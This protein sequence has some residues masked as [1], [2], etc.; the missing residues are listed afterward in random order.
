MTLSTREP[1]AIRAAVVAAVNA[2]FKVF[3]IAGIIAIGPE[4]E[5]AVITAVDLVATAVLVVWTRGK[6]TPVAAPLLPDDGVPFSI[7]DG[8]GRYRAEE[9]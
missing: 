6:V 9:V 5:V 4:V 1:L 2:V 8:T 3:V 7:P